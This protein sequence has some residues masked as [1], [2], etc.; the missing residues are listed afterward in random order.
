[1]TRRV[2]AA[3][4]LCLAAVAAP[5]QV[6]KI[7]GPEDGGPTPQELLQAAV[8]NSGY[9]HFYSEQIRTLHR[10][11]GGVVD[12]PVFPE[13]WDFVFMGTE[14]LEDGWTVALVRP[15]SESPCAGFSV[16]FPPRPGDFQYSRMKAPP[17]LDEEALVRLQMLRA[18]R[19]EVDGVLGAGRHMYVWAPTP[20]PDRAMIYAWAEVDQAGAPDADAIQ[21]GAAV[22]VYVGGGIGVYQARQVFISHEAPL[23]WNRREAPR[24]TPLEIRSAQEAGVGH[25]TPFDFLRARCNPHLR[26][27]LFRSAEGTLLM[28]RDG[29]TRPLAEKELAR[30]ANLPP[31][32]FPKVLPAAPEFLRYA[33]ESKKVARPQEEA[34]DQNTVEP[35]AAP[36]VVPATAPKEPPWTRYS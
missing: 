26:P 7:A 31:A 29:G 3:A 12:C 14:T 30:C 16:S 20:S 9:L 34:P 28:E 10:M 11:M 24:K 25:L 22:I 21:I 35:E 27:R 8:D 6:F 33:A 36:P 32:V 23:G 15:G 5:T 2:L 17:S 18:A 13:P 4:A 19:A 1:M